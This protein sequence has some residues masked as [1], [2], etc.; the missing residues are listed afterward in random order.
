MKAHLKQKPVASCTSLAMVFAYSNPDMS[1]PWV[2]LEG[3]IMKSVKVNAL[4]QPAFTVTSR[5]FQE[6][7][8]IS[9]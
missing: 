3:R 8:G 9:L 5:P 6:T 2:S 7:L 4:S 1:M